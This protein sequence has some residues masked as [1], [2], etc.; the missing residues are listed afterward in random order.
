MIRTPGCSFFWIKVK[1]FILTWIIVS[2]FLDIRSSAQF[3]KSNSLLREE[4]F[5]EACLFKEGERSDFFLFNYEVLHYGCT[6][7]CLM[8]T[9]SSRRHSGYFD[10]SITVPYYFNSHRCK[11][12]YHECQYGS[13]KS[14]IPNQ[15][16]TTTITPNDVG[17]IFLE[18]K[19]G[20]VGNTNA[21]EKTLP[22]PYLLFIS[23]YKVYRTKTIPNTYRPVW[24]EEFTIPKA[25]LDENI[26]L[27]VMDQ[28][29]NID[30]E[31]GVFVILPKSVLDQGNNGKFVEY[32]FGPARNYVTARLTWYNN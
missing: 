12:E 2:L 21:Y 20:Y 7:K 31:L 29:K 25:R 1:A 13:C 18:I 24:N 14:S 15:P 30:D 3:S 16:Q 10:R 6:V 11:D 27:H 28:D 26:T 19:E 22:D 17:V 8:L 9:S 4:D 5:K 23:N 32:A